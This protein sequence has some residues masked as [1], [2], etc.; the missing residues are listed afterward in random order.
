MSET[1]N[2]AQAGTGLLLDSR[3]ELLRAR[4]FSATSIHTPKPEDPS[5]T[6]CGGRVMLLSEY[7]Q[8]GELF[9]VDLTVCAGADPQ[10]CK[11]CEASVAKRQREAQ[12]SQVVDVHRLQAEGASFEEAL[13]VVS[14]EPEIPAEA[15]AG[16]MR[17]RGDGVTYHHTTNGRNAR[18]R[19]ELVA[20]GAIL[21]QAQMD[22]TLTSVRHTRICP[23]CQ[24]AP[25]SEPASPDLAEG[26]HVLGTQPAAAD[27]D[28]GRSYEAAVA[29][30]ALRD[31]TVRT[32]VTVA[33]PLTST[34]DVLPALEMLPGIVQISASGRD[35]IIYRTQES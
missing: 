16:W 22:E 30:Q 26:F 15:E 23:S 20:F 33:A 19:R 12:V 21:A 17:T 2:T 6:L 8:D 14:A 31:A 27:G 18:C 24:A 1:T 34:A 4:T 10:L 28:G 13:A 9:Q 35:V 7:L 5:R 32:V 29:R 3:G 11:R 25:A